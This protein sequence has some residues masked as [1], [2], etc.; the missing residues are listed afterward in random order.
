MYTLKMDITQND[1]QR[2]ILHSRFYTTQDLNIATAMMKGEFKKY[3]EFLKG[4]KESIYIR[5]LDSQDY[6]VSLVFDFT[7]EDVYLSTQY[8]GA[9]DENF[10]SHLLVGDEYQNT[11]SLTSVNESYFSE[12]IEKP[13]KLI[14][15]MYYDDIV[16]FVN[17]EIQRY[18]HG[19]EVVEKLVASVVERQKE[20]EKAEETEVKD[21]LP[22][23]C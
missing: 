2:Y 5:V 14:M 12:I 7:Q 22:E 1:F 19:A 21:I 4:I 11:I 15:V 8:K 18:Q 3:L 6:V 9:N 10:I 13:S 23:E 17:E 16:S 20:E